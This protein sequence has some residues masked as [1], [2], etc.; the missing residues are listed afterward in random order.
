VGGVVEVKG[1]P[2]R[3]DRWHARADINAVDAGAVVEGPLAE[4][5]SLQAAGTYS[6]LGEVIKAA[7]R[8][9]A[10]AI[11]PLYRDAYARLDWA[12][13]PGNR[14][15]TT[16]SASRDELEIVTPDAS[17]G[18]DELSGDRREAATSDGFHMGLLGWNSRF[19]GSLSN[20]FR[21]SYIQS[22]SR[23]SLF[24]AARFGA[25]SR[26]FGLR[27]E[28][29]FAPRP[30][31][32]VIPGL[33]CNYER[34]DFHYGFATADGIA[35]GASS[36]HIANLG[37]Y[38]NAE[39]RPITRWLIAPGARYDYYRE[40]DQG[41]PAY[42]LASRFEYLPGLTAKGSA[43]TY[44]QAP[45]FAGITVEGLGNPDLPP[46]EA[47]H[48][49]LGNEWRITDLLTLDAQAYWNTQSHMP[50]ATDSLDPATGKAYN[51]LPGM[52][53][54]MYGLE[55]MLRH[56]RGRRFFGWVA[57][58]LSRAERRAPHPF[59]AE[60]YAG[61]QDRD[62]DAWIPAERDQTHNL[63]V[64]GSWRLP[65]GWEAGFRFRYVTGNPATPLL[66]LS[67]NRFRYDS[68]AR[69]YAPEPGKPFSDR[70]GPFTQLDF[71]VDKKFV[72]QN[73]ILST[74]LDVS[75]A[76]YFFYNSPEI[77]AYNY[78][79]SRR[80]TIG[81]LFLPSLGFTTEF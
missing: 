25:H 18:S 49:T 37:A 71:R 73:W 44:T 75:N 2:A 11:A 60:L 19:S 24:G 22:E 57:Y 42:R 4:G 79:N 27:E 10:T 7:T 47:R 45:K 74:Y 14:V 21:L 72:Y 77:Y 63:Q 36:L 9:Q 53:G 54:R 12:L 5:L 23:G 62:P 6:Y 52:E 78:D 28:L 32:A 13:S 8:N 68:D 76:N 15:F 34:F 16:Y 29:R 35:D 80:K 55:L 66:P 40:V 1:R 41:L 50:G 33:D 46:V 26:G 43:G 48:F 65:R 56:D 58:T 20:E 38:A 17:G 39:I 51:F 31:I 59:A 81:A 70:V 69:A 3:T 67:E 64:V 61:D 30:W